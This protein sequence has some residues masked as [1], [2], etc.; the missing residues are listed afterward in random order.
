MRETLRRTRGVL[1]RS[2]DRRDGRLT[3]L[4]VL[5]AYPVLYLVSLGHL[6]LGGGGGV[7]LLV[8]PDPVARAFAAR[9]PFSYEPVAR[10]AVGP[11]L[12]LVAPLNLLIGGVLALLVAANAAVAVVT[13][14]SP[15]ACG[16]GSRSGPI[17]GALGLLSGTACCGP[18]VLFVLG[19]QATGTLLTAFGALVPTA[20]ALLVGSLL[21]TGRRAGPD[22]PAGDTGT[23]NAG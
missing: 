7:G 1:A 11:V 23:G 19:V 3:F 9:S 17:A 13:T 14:R 15:A 21:L 6:T 22:G 18:A 2:L 20:A 12:W 8:V 5:V 4:A 10:V 16:V